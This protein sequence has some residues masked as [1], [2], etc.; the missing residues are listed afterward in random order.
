MARRRSTG[1]YRHGR[2]WKFAVKDPSSG[3][4]K[5]L[6]ATAAR[7][8]ALRVSVRNPA[9][10]TRTEV[11]QLRDRY[12]ERLGLTSEQGLAAQ[13][14]VRLV[15]AVEDFLRFQRNTPAFLRDK[16]RVLEEFGDVVGNVELSAVTRDDLAE[17]EAR[18]SAE[19]RK[20]HPT[21]VARYLR[22]LR[23]FF[24]FALREEWVTRSPFANFRIPRDAS[25]PIEVYALDEL[26]SLVTALRSS[27]ENGDRGYALW[28]LQ[29]CLGLGLRVMEL[30][31]LDWE[32][33]DEKQ[34]FVRISKTKNA[35]SQR[36]QP[37]PRVLMSEFVR[38]ASSGPMFPAQSGERANRNQ[39]SSLRCRIA[40]LSPGFS[41]RRLRRTYATLLQAGGVDSLI[42]DRLLGHSSRSSAVRVS[43]SHYIGKEYSFY[44]DLVDEALKPLGGVFAD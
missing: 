28:M 7:F 19:S 27:G 42:I 9:S 37:I 30:E 35:Q 32:D 8:R 23:T 29:G 41:W 25:T 2:G 40:K 24:N 14:E 12:Q 44:R 10:V 20:L 31:A 16:R 5:Q 11:A 38:R 22:Y 21:S 39:M 43:A 13:D 26:R 36:L 34:R 4:W 33:F 6:T 1:I 3:K 18:L 15:R 17:F